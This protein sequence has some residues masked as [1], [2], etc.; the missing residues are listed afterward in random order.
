MHPRQSPRAS[1]NIRHGANHPYW[2]GI[3]EEL[4]DAIKPPRRYT[5]GTNALVKKSAAVKA[6]LSGGAPCNLQDTQP[7]QTP[8][9]EARAERACTNN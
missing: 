2:H 6:S 1:N 9:R 7:N 3:R 5:N 4:L 8:A